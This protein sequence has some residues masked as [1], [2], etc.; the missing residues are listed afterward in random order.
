MN[1]ISNLDWKDYESKHG[2]VYIAEQDNGKFLV[3][4]SD[5]EPIFCI[6]ADSYSDIDNRLSVIYKVWYQFLQE[7]SKKSD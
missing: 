1:N 4:S 5:K 3:A 7:R 2:L 6:E